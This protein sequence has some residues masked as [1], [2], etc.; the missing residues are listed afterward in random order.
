M[1]RR[2]R[3]LEQ[4]D[5]VLHRATAYCP[6]LPR[7]LMFSLV[8]ELADDGVPITVAHRV[9]KAVPQQYYRYVDEPF[10]SAELDEASLANAIFDAHR[11][12]PNWG[13]RFLA[14][15]SASTAAVVSNWVMWRTGRDRQWWS[16]FGKPKEAEA[17]KPG[18]P[19]HDH[20][21]RRNVTADAPNVVWLAD[22]TEHWTDEGKLYYRA[23]KDL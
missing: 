3:L 6:S 8:R 23:I 17:S 13:Y 14:M 20:L 18:A 11:D 12:D 10:G 9:L 22:I 1:K 2:L 4:E 7:M 21:V 16:V 5:P 19:S 15:R